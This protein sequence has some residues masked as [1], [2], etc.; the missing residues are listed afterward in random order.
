MANDVAIFMLKQLLLREVARFYKCDGR[1]WKVPVVS[2]LRELR[3]TNLQAVFFGGTLRSLLVE[4]VF[5][6]HF[7]R[8]RD[9]D[10]V[11]SGSSVEILRSTFKD[12]ISRET[13]FGGLQL[14][15]DN[16]QFDVWPL[17][18]TWSF[19]HEGIVDPEFSLLPETTFFNMEAIAV[20][21]WPR[22]G[23][24]R[25]IFSGDEQFFEGLLS[26][27]LEI[28]Q[29]TNP[30]PSL[31]V[32]RSLV[33]AASLGFR[34]GPGLANYITEHGRSMTAADFDALQI[35]HYGCRRHYGE[36]LVS[37][38][39]YVSELY[40]HGET[41]QIRLPG[42]QLQFWEDSEESIALR[43]HSLTEGHHI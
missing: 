4:R 9:V 24:P 7:G 27:T 38:V 25:R 36:S 26:R 15:R 18:K 19:V 10:I 30:F 40:L 28:N 5:G 11:V 8:P 41:R 32:L 6:N 20:E 33:M 34:I 14:R 23:R 21:V 43:V 17:H 35:K 37:W 31:C 39:E 42:E 2:T 22:P 16:W 3:E 29:A 12:I 13:R 1:A